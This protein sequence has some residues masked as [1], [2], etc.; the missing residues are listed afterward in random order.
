LEIATAMGY[1]NLKGV[2]E[3]SG[4]G[5]AAG[6]QIFELLH[7]KTH[8]QEIKLRKHDSTRDT[9]SIFVRMPLKLTSIP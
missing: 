5:H 2:A 4:T 7:T 9:F 8:R 1:M 3:I 6:D